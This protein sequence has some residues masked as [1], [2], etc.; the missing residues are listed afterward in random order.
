MAKP[1]RTF[2]IGD[3][4]FGHEGM[5]SFTNPDGSK[6]R[7]WHNLEDMHRDM[8]ERWNDTVRPRDRVIHL[9]DFAWNRRS[10]Y[11]IPKLHGRKHLVLGNHDV[12]QSEDYLRTT[13]DED[14]VELPNPTRFVKLWGA[15]VEHKIIFTH[16]PVHPSTLGNRFAINIHGHLHNAV[17]HNQEFGTVDGRYY[18]VSCEQT[19]F[20]PIELE[21]L[22]SKRCHPQMVDQLLN[23]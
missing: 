19:D 1:S 10:L 2:V 8:I 6:L 20:R 17:I 7:P 21:E 23:R 12:F 5:C 11:I 3:T 16:L 15:Y 14:G 9:G 22:L 18:N 4:H 13:H